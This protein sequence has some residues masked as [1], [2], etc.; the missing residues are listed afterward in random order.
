MA[1]YGAVISGWMITYWFK[2]LNWVI[3]T[4]DITAR[5]AFFK[6]CINQIIMSP[7]LNTFFFG[8]VTFTRKNKEI[9]ENGGFNGKLLYLKKKLARDLFPTIKRS[10]VYWGIVQF[11]NFCYLPPKYMLL[12]TNLA[13]V[14]WTTYTSFVGFRKVI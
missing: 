3:P 6:V 13:F 8:Y 2:F 1:L 9:G 14:V 10:C 7:G 11:I 4:K 12:Y 5:R